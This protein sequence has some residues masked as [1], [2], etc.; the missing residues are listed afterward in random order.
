MIARQRILLALVAILPALGSVQAQD[1]AVTLSA[2]AAVPLRF[3]TTISSGTHTR[4]QQ[5]DLEVTDDINVNG[6]I[7]I[8]AGSIALGEVVHADRARGLGKAGE[9]ILAARH[10][11]VG[12]RQIKLR[13]QLSMTGQDKTMQAA[14][15]VPWIKG[16]NLEVPAE[17]EVIARTVV[18][19]KFEIPVKTT[20]N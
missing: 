15:L 4:G 10:V 19:E 11:K 16:K 9:L 13:S 20:N 14:F 12:E 1:A 5:F 18:D 7:V 17:T 2:N 8:P 6:V 3:V